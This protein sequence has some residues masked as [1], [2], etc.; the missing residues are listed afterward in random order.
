MPNDGRWLSV[1][2]FAWE[3]GKSE[4]TIR[5]MLDRGALEFRDWNAGGTYR[6]AQI[7][8]RELAR[9]GRRQR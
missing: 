6:K 9:I 8:A 2:E 4:K 3:A 7:P 5:R 1:S